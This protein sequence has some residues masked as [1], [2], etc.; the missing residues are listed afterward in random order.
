[1]APDE[2]VKKEFWVAEDDPDDRALLEDAFTELHSKYQLRFFSDGQEV[3]Y[4]AGSAGDHF[5]CLVVLD[6]KMPS[7][8]G[9]QVI[10]AIKKLENGK[11]F[12]FILLT[13]SLN[14]SDSKKAKELEIPVLSK[15]SS[16]S[17]LLELL[18]SLLL[19]ADKNC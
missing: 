17:A 14:A 16:F 12:D 9:V 11:G 8:N 2:T 15:P 4:A 1:M 5:P 6:G 13:G 10:E 19:K 18:T 7:M 3:V